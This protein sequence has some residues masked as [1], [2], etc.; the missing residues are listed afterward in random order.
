MRLRSSS[1]TSLSFACMRSRRVFRCTTNWPRCD[2]P[3]MKMKP[4]NLKVSGFPSPALA[5]LTA[6]WRPNSI[7]RVLSGCSES[8]NSCNRARSASQNRRASDSNSKP[9]TS[10]VAERNLTSPPSQIRTGR[11]RVI[12]LLPPSLRPHALFPQNKQL[13]VPPRD[14]SQPVHR[15][16]FSAFEPLKLP[17]HP[18]SEGL[19]EMPEHLNALRAVEPPVVVQPAPH[20]RVGESRQILQALVI[21]GGRHPPITDGLANPL[22]GL[23]TD[24]RQEIDKELSPPVLCSSRV[25]GVPEEVE[26]NTFV[27]SPAVIIPAVDDLGLRWM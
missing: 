7:R 21:P 26:L 20:H 8:A 13:G 24:R 3:Q 17:S 19:V 9:T 2:L 1:L 15:R 23:G 11:S 27:S 22:G 14:A 12:R 5:R 10:R 18:L 4:R 6:A 16:A 25:E